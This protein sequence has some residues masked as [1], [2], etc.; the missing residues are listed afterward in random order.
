MFIFKLFLQL[1][2]EV[3]AIHIEYYNE[4]PEFKYCDILYSYSLYV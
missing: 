3:G 2:S 4:R 1:F